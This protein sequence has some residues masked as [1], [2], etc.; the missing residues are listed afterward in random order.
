MIGTAVQTHDI[1]VEEIFPHTPAT[2]WKALTA[3][4]LVER[5]IRMPLSGFDAV[6]GKEF[7]FKTTPAGAWDGLIRCRVIEAVPNERLAY[8]W[9]SGDAANDGYGAPLDTIV[10]WT[11]TPSKNGT[12][13]RL[14]HAGF[15]LPRNEGAYRNMGE[16]WKQVVKTIDSLAGE[17]N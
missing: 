16:G 6:A 9:K 12:R 8:S 4:A 13:L 7:T 2:I 3:G 14:V 10:T 15:V 5:W 17:L 1:V 11:L